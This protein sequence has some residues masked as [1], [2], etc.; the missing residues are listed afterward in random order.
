MPSEIDPSDFYNMDELLSPDDLAVRRQRPVLC[1]SAIHARGSAALS[2]L[3]HSRWNCSVR[4]EGCTVSCDYSG[5]Y[6]C[7]G[8][9][10]LAYGL[11]MRELERGDSGLRTMASVQGALAMNA[12]YY[13]GSE[14]QKRKWLPEMV[15]GEKIGCFGLTEPEFGSNPAGMQTTA[16]PQAVH[17]C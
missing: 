8:L 12:I 4:W 2:R 3:A 1:R 16:K 7:A 17:M 11:I 9:S 10:N 6:G 15:R 13:F 14:E 5:E